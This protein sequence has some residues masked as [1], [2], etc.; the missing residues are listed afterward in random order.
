M[1][2]S[3]SVIPIVDGLKQLRV[4]D[5]KD[6]KLEQLP[7]EIGTLIYLRFL[8]LSNTG[9]ERLPASVGKLFNLLTL[10]IGSLPNI[11]ILNGIPAGDWIANSLVKLASLNRL[12][13]RE[14]SLDHED[15]L[16]SALPQLQCLNYLALVVEMKENDGVMI[17]EETSFNPTNLPFKDLNRLFLLTL[18]G[19]LERLPNA[20]EFPTQLMKLTLTLS[21]LDQDPMPVLGQLRSLESLKLLQGSYTGRQMVCPPSSFPKLKFFKLSKLP[22]GEWKLEYRAMISLK[23][24]VIHHCSLLKMLP[25]GLKHARDLQELELDSM[26]TRFI[27]RVRENGG[28]DLHKIHG[29]TPI[30]LINSYEG[31]S[32]IL[33]KDGRR[34]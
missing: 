25:E 33:Y 30:S 18:F 34:S 12:T 24:L 5:L 29:S 28:E 8:G 14:I 31:K 6:V 15:A 23:R 22:L 17:E 7:E 20:N 9:L 16:A 10:D 32:Y 19:R 21:W 11:Q 26:P 13:I 2:S 3:Q 4:I 27:N 1:G